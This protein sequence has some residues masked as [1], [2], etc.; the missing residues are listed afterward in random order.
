M[1]EKKIILLIST[2]MIIDYSLI[3]RKKRGIY[4][5]L[6]V[7]L[8][9]VPASTVLCSLILS[10]IIMRVKKKNLS[11]LSIVSKILLNY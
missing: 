9:T 7:G 8:M 6:S 10:F 11:I 4:I 3:Q 1:V 5:I 2:F